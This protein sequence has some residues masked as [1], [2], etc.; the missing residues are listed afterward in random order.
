MGAWALSSSQYVQSSVKN[1]EE[2]VK[3]K[4]NLNV[5]S[6]AETTIQKLYWSELGVSMDLTPVLVSHYISLIGILR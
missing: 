1:V 5:P 4:Y 2:Y 3:D 6:R